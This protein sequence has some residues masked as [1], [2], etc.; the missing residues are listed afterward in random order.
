VSDELEVFDS[1]GQFL[2]AHVDD[3]Y[4]ASFEL[5]TSRPADPEYL[6]DQL[7]RWIERTSDRLDYS[8]VDIGSAGLPELIEAVRAARRIG[9]EP[10]LM[11]AIR[12]LF[13]R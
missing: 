8:Q 9:P 3:E 12:R 5:D 4:A 6:A 7:R 11:N 2:K 1:T 13:R 10:T